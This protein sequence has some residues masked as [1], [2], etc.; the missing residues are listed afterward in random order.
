MFCDLLL[1]RICVGQFLSTALLCCLVL[2]SFVISD[3]EAAPATEAAIKSEKSP[4]YVVTKPTA[5]QYK[6]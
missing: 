4:T 2:F 1:R 3:I 5:A 6:A